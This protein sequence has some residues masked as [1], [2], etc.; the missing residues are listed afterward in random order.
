[1]QP[2]VGPRVYRSSAMEII[3]VFYHIYMF[4]LSCNVHTT[5][6]N[7]HIAN[8]SRDIKPQTG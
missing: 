8:S 7:N 2:L 5:T 4:V 3:S 1:M 6:S